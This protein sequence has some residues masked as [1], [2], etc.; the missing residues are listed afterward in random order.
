MQSSGHNSGV[1][2][3]LL[4]RDLLAAA[5]EVHFL[6]AVSDQARK[7]SGPSSPDLLIDN[8]FAAFRYTQPTL[9]SLRFLVLLAQLQQWLHRQRR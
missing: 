7:Q 9:R 1:I 8:R 5:I 4:Y 2:Q 3:L 6:V